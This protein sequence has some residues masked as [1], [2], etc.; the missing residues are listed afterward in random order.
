MRP[1]AGRVWWSFY[2]PG[3]TFDHFVTRVL[4][5]V[6]GQGRAQLAE[7]PVPDCE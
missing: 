1:L 7:D 2:Q 5:Y 4:M 6:T 3:V